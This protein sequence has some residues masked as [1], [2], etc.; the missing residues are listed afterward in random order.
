MQDS[1][2][3]LTMLNSAP[4]PFRF[5]LFAIVFV[6]GISFLNLSLVF[7][8][9]ANVN[10][11]TINATVT[12]IAG[13][14]P[15]ANLQKCIEH[16]AVSNDWTY[17]EQITGRVDCRKHNITNLAG[18]E[19]LGNITSLDISINYISDINPLAKLYKLEILKLSF[20]TVADLRPLASLTQL[21]ILNISNNMVTDITTLANLY[22][23]ENLNLQNNLIT[24]ISPI[25]GLTALESL[26]LAVNAVND[27]N[28]LTHLTNLKYLSL[29]NNDI[30]DIT[31]LEKL[32][33][34]QGLNLRGNHIK[35]TENIANLLKLS[36]LNLSDNSI[37]TNTVAGLHALTSM[38]E[39]QYVNLS[40]NQQVSCVALS[41]LIAELKAANK[42]VVPAMVQ[43]DNGCSDQ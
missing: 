10:R 1:F 39:L 7:A 35:N 14:F 23:L 36:N 5:Q 42:V 12:P 41:S 16:I 38:P 34:L 8:T 13:L 19:T 25:S 43:L 24:N 9:D 18:I 21:R 30:T 15:D 31:G 29:L 27:I 2:G 33:N 6:F 37:E 40:G 11:N 3:N 22:Q 32:T 20:N 4:G 28:A 26:D 17:A